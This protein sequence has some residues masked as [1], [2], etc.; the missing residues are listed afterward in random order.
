MP[1]LKLLTSVP[2][3]DKERAEIL[4]ALSRLLAETTGKPETYVMVTLEE[5]AV[6]MAGKAGPAA[7]VDIRAIGGLGGKKNKEI[8]SAVC[9]FLSG[10]LAIPPERV[11]ITFSDFPAADWGWKSGTF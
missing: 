1:L 8:S 4:A 11:Y 9:S 3:G 10:A 5:G 7:F 2:L 6:L